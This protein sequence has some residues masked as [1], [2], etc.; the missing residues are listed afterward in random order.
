MEFHQHLSG[1]LEAVASGLAG[2]A[3]ALGDRSDVAP[4]GWIPVDTPL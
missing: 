1:D 4:F 2:A 3:A